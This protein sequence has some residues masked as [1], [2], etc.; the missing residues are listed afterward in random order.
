MFA[1]FFGRLKIPFIAIMNP[2]G[3]I[4]K[5]MIHPGQYE[6]TSIQRNNGGRE[7]RP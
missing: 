1:E 6:I 5:I 3:I 2:S 7:Y 4:T